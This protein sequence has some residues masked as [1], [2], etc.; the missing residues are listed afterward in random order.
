MLD[1][2][3]PKRQ[4]K[5]RESVALNSILKSEKDVKAA[6]KKALSFLGAFQV[7]PVPT[8]MGS[9]MV[10]HFA[11][12]PV[13]ITQDMIGRTIGVF[14]AIEAKREGVNAPTER[15]AK[16][17]RSAIDAGGAALLIASG[18][19]LEVEDAIIVAAMSA[20]VKERTYLSVVKY[21]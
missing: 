7:S 19:V 15:Q 14:V 18:S 21:Y 9:P 10:D 20:G 13:N 2:E 1:Q 17:L 3:K 12:V 5:P 11:C 4:R 8:G 6:I 16:V